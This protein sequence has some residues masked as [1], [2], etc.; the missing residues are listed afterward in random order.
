[1]AC[2]ARFKD[3]EQKSHGHSGLI[4]REHLEVNDHNHNHQAQGRGEVQQA[5]GDVSEHQFILP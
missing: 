1:M 5:H 4:D 2:W 3:P